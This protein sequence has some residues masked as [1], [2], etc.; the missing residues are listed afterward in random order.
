MYSTTLSCWYI[1]DYG[2]FYFSKMSQLHNSAML[3]LKNIPFW[4]FINLTLDTYFS[5][6]AVVNS[7]YYKGY[8][9]ADVFIGQ[10]LYF[11]L[12]I[13][14]INTDCKAIW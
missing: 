1:L 14:L 11:F 13:Y 7:T 12:I 3:W 4:I 5:Y 10:K 8:G 6:L 9:S 2:L